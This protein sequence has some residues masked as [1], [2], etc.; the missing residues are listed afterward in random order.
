MP[1]VVRKNGSQYCVYNKDTGDKKGCHDSRDKANKQMGLLYGIE[2]GSLKAR[3]KD[4]ET[5]LE[6][7]ILLAGYK[8]TMAYVP[9]TAQERQL[10]QSEAGYTAYGATDGQG[11]ANC[12][13]YI[14]PDACLLVAGSI[15]PTGKSNLWRQQQE[16]T[17]TPLPVFVTNKDN[18]DNPT[19]HTEG[20]LDK[21]TSVFKKILG[22]RLG[23]FFGKTKEG[24]EQSGQKIPPVSGAGSNSFAVFKVKD[25]S[26]QDRLRFLAYWSNCFKDKK[27]DIIPTAALKEYISWAEKE[28]AYPPVVLWHTLG[29]EF[30]QVDWMEESNGFAVASGLVEPGYEPLAIKLADDGCG[31][32][33]G[34]LYTQNQDTSIQ[35]I[36]AWELSALP[37]HRT[38][39]PWGTSFMVLAGTKEDGIQSQLESM[40]AFA[41]EK[42][43][44]L[45][46]IGG[47]TDEQI[48]E[49]ERRTEEFAKSLKGMG[50]DWKDDNPIDLAGTQQAIIDLA[51]Q[52]KSALDG[53][54]T[55]VDTA[56]TSIDEKVGAVTKD[57]EGKLDAAVAGTLAAGGKP[58]VT[59]TPPATPG[60]PTTMTTSPPAVHVASQSDDTVIPSTDPVLKKDTG[61]FRQN[62]GFGRK[63]EGVVQ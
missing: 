36:R 1:Y 18:P 49:A 52:V 14:E 57:I 20:S 35:A 5:G 27:Q 62:V 11:C 50:I 61:W 6:E 3:K 13:W 37:A 23:G 21:T 46:D 2:S 34:S 28:D 47:L 54:N 44:F 31:M 45:K 48:G 15:S 19:E 29:T 12:Q 8:D 26:G 7:E 25:N 17:P 43:A 24:V 56:V 39:N 41:P 32:S 63:P 51:T 22:D 4:D 16:Y 42:R 9:Y 38:G 30:A 10:T 55:K 60:A 40:M 33:H 59:V 58:N 53:L